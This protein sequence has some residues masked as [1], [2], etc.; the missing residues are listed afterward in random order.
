MT[1]TAGESRFYPQLVHSNRSGISVPPKLMIPIYRPR[2]E[3]SPML[4]YHPNIHRCEHIKVNVTQ[5]GSPSIRG[6][7][8]L[9]LILERRVVPK[10]AACFRLS[11]VVAYLR[12]RL[13]S[14]LL[15]PGRD[16][17]GGTNEE[18]NKSNQCDDSSGD[19]AGA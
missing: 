17:Q 18:K 5:C 11:D 15:Q 13:W 4:L 16:P 8:F 10:P 19:Y 3:G 1:I 2:G 7:S 12:S 6:N 14:V 9:G